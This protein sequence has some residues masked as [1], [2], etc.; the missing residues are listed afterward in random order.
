MSPADIFSAAELAQLLD[1]GARIGLEYGELDVLRDRD[2]GRIY[3]V[4]VNRTPYGPGS[5]GRDPTWHP[6]PA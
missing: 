3:V 2:S 5:V 6:S 4:D 1:F